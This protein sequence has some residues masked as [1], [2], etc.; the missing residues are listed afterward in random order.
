MAQVA[1]G[2]IGET[3]KK[4]YFCANHSTGEYAGCGHGVAIT[5]RT[6]FCMGCDAPLCPPCA[7]QMCELCVDEG[8]DLAVDGYPG[9]PERLPGESFAEY[10]LRCREASFLRWSKRG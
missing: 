4:R 9:N 2:C 7:G 3:L 5:R 8:I 10:E 1:M 6:P